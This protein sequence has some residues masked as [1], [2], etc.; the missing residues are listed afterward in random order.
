MQN[1]GTEV[2]KKESFQPNLGARR[3]KWTFGPTLTGS[4]V[5]CQI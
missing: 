5:F 3:L 1:V 2:Y 4:K